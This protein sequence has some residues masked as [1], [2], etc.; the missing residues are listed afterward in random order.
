MPARTEAFLEA[1]RRAGRLGELVPIGVYTGP[2]RDHPVSGIAQDPCNYSGN[3]MLG[4]VLHSKNTLDL[5]YIPLARNNGAAVFPL[6]E[7]D[8][9]EPLE[10][11]GYRVHFKQLDPTRPLRRESG[12]VRG[13]TVI[14]AGGTLGSAE[15]LLR[16]RDIYKTLP[17]LSPTLGQR[18]SGNGDMLLGFTAGANHTIDPG[19]GPSI[20]AGADFST[21]NN[22]IYIEDPGFPDP[23]MWMLE[24][25]IPTT[26][27]VRNILRALKSY[28]LDAIGVGNG[29]IAFEADRLFRGGATTNML[30]YLGMGTDA[31]N[32]RIRLKKGSLDISWNPAKSKAMFREMERGLKELSRGLD[33][34]YLPSLLWKWP[35]RKLLTAHPLGGCCMGD[36]PV[37]SVV[38]EDGEVWA[39]PGLYVADAG[40]IPSALAVNPS[41]TIS[42]LAERIAYKMIH[43]QEI[44]QGGAPPS[45][46]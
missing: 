41:L 17:N 38:N 2:E 40:I 33:G 35:F 14:V 32:G 11:Q 4:C 42:A 37:G 22:T 30:P 28:V 16:C 18:F 44:D 9:I 43:Q 24:G 13:A 36:D 21:Q 12:S 7:V 39:Y 5:N 15:L 45:D 23:F 29:R 20:T 19:R 1:A 46:R 8:R 26:N 31:A 27:R 34:K 10:E 6:H 3:C 25:A